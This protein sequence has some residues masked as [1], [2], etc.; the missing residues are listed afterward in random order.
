MRILWQCSAAGIKRVVPDH[1]L[2]ENAMIIPPY[3]SKGLINE[4]A[5]PS[6]ALA[7]ITCMMPAL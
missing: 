7:P 5:S 6:A 4:K 2:L 3:H 1:A